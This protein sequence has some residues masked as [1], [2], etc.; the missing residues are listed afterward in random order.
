MEGLC[1]SVAMTL[2]LVFD[3]RFLFSSSAFVAIS[4]LETAVLFS[5]HEGVLIL[6]F[7][8]AAPSSW[9]GCSCFLFTLSITD[10]KCQFLRFIKNDEQTI[11]HTTI[12]SAQCTVRCCVASS[13]QLDLDIRVD[14][15]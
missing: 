2:L 6:D 5:S 3:S 13:V 9:I 10:S 7:L 11:Q 1:S 8:I 14:F 4:T 12:H 15:T